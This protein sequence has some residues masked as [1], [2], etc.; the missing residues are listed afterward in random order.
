MRSSI[1]PLVANCYMEQLK[2]VAI[3][4]SPHPTS[5]WLRYVDRTSRIRRGRVHWTHKQHR[6][7]HEIHH[8]TW[9]RQQTSLPGSMHPYSGWWI[10][11]DNYLHEAD[12]HGPVPQLLVMSPSNPQTFSCTHPHLQG[13]AVCHHSRRQEI[14][15][16]TSPQCPESQWIP[17]MGACTSTIQ[18][19]K[20]T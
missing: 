2:K 11:E 18:C 3:Y 14:R 20:K 9:G 5:L 1:Y 12:T 4:T 8:R 7:T 16:S 17:R 15:T 13:T 6:S 10:H 19:K